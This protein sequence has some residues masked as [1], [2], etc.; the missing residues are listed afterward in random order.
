[1][2]SQNLEV[3]GEVIERYKASEVEVIIIEKGKEVEYYIKEPEIEKK[4]MEKI[5]TFIENFY[6]K[7][8]IPCESSK[9]ALEKEIEGLS[10]SI[11]YHTRKRVSS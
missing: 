9:K 5:T 4:E 8:D 2:E 6:S 3:E 10:S 1:M 11:Q 7:K